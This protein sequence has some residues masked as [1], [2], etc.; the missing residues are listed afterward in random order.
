MKTYQRKFIEN[1]KLIKENLLKIKNIKVS[2][3][4]VRFFKR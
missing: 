3:E 1:K 4:I 2:N